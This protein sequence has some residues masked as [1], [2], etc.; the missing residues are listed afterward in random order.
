MGVNPWKESTLQFKYFTQFKQIIYSI[1]TNSE[2]GG[3]W[4]QNN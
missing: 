3:E 4:N 2:E 1:S